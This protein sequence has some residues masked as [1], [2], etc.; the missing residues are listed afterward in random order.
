MKKIYFGLLFIFSI[1]S[2]KSQSVVISQ[3]YGGGGN[4]SA[5]Y[6]N[7]F[8]E[9]FNATSGTVSINNWS[10]QYASAA[11][12]FTSAVNLTGS[13]AAGQYYLVKLATGGAI[14]SLLP[15]ADA[16]NTA[17]NISASAGKIALVSSTTLLGASCTGAT[18]V[19]LVGYG[20]SASCF[21]GAFGPAGSN[22]T[23]IFRANNGC[24]DTQN[25]SSDFAA[26]SPN[27]RNTSSA[28]NLCSVSC[29]IP[30][31]SASNLR[32]ASFPTSTSMSML[33]DR[34]NGNGA[35]V[36]AKAA[37]SVTSAPVTGT[38]YTA[39]STFGSGTQIGTGNYVVYQTLLPG[40]V[41]FTVSGLVTG[42]KYY[43][44]VY[45]YNDPGKCYNSSPAVDS[46]TM[47]S[48]ILQPG[49]MAILGWDNSLTGGYD[50]WYL[51]NL[52]PI[53]KGT[54]FSLCNSRF[55]TGAAAN[56]R[57]NHWGG[58][59]S[60]PYS[61]PEKQDFEYVGSTIPKGSIIA[62]EASAS[63]FINFTINGVSVPATDFSAQSGFSNFLSVTDPDQ[64]FITQGRYTAYGTAGVDRYNLLSGKVI[65]GVSIGQA[66]IPLTSAVST[67]TGGGSSRQS[68]IPPD[69][70]CINTEF[71]TMNTPSSF[72]YYNRS[73]GQVGSKKVLIGK[74]T[75]LSNW[76]TGV[77]TAGADDIIAADA[78]YATAGYTVNTTIPDGTWNGNSNTNWFD[79]SNWEGLHVP[80]SSVEVVIQ[81]MPT[82]LNNC[83]I[84]LTSNAKAKEYV[85]KA[86]CDSL[87]L[88]PSSV[89]SLTGTGNEN[90]TT[91]NG[92]TIGQGATLSFENN[93]NANTDTLFVHN[94]FKDLQT[95][96]SLG[97][98][99]G[100]GTVSFEDQRFAGTMA[101]VYRS[102]L[103]LSFYNMR[104]NNTRGISADSDI[105]VLHNLNL[106]AGHITTKQSRLFKLFTS[107]SLTSPT[108]VYGQ[109]NSGYKSSFVNGRMY[110]ESSSTNSNIV[111]PIGKI[112]GTDTLYAPV[113][114]NKASSSTITYNA[115]YFNTAYTDVIT[116]T[117]PIDHV[118]SLEYWKV[119][120]DN[121]NTLADVKLTLSW[122]PNSKVGDGNAADN[123]SALSDLVVAHYFND[124][125]GNK[126]NMEGSSAATFTTTSVGGTADV[127]YG[128]IGQLNN[129]SSS[130]LAYPYF[131]LGTKSLFNALPVR[132]IKFTAIAKNNITELSWAAEQEGTVAKYFIERSNDGIRFSSILSEFPKN[133]S[134][135]NYY[136]NVDLIPF[137]GYNYYRLVTID[138]AGKKLYSQVEKVWFGEKGFSI[139]PSPVH[140]ELFIN[141]PVSSNAWTVE[142]VS[143]TGQLLYRSIGAS[144]NIKIDMSSFSNGVYVVKAINGLQVISQ[145]IT[146]L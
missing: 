31:I 44:Y 56:V 50:K 26:A 18:V 115:E 49:D 27:P 104:M 72:A 93:T 71:A 32:L 98:V 59:G 30:T 9:I 13:L 144:G 86:Y 19:D 90:L 141:L 54:G 100:Q 123:A 87:T 75:N 40:V 97:L 68:R 138:K 67:G 111:F 122:R 57:T 80:D 140:N 60:S 96:G 103:N 15:T 121:N 52:V 69:I 125:A 24:T 23:S 110:Y 53:T 20:A 64:V 142:M 99:A 130:M 21:E 77:G 112:S 70:L 16:T 129:F 109:T 47:G 74:F 143:S 37:S 7:D 79:C 118:S 8:V 12:N 55:E 101:S 133:Y 94:F 43:F 128:R 65:Y 135:T 76:V 61:D 116:D 6:Q 106:N 145:R 63:G 119:E 29:S 48:T 62:F 84:D 28:V 117:L 34:G 81:S 35:I 4:A 46:F 66:W 126:W 39:N 107:S 83:N 114:L 124:G 41:G 45:E 82:A 136:N 2:V 91:D 3:I 105:Y 22:T 95:S 78:S 14:G 120:S 5:P 146:K 131:T 11:G 42:T 127:S 85:S 89:L 139:Y 33:F 137:K 132:L 73:N 113:Y 108:N 1:L 88:N 38:T 92:V 25:N 51:M 102:S 58:G 17:I 10:I 134:V 36:V